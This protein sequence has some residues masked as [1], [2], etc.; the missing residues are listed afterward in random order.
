MN[1]T[2]KS[3]CWT[4]SF[5]GWGLCSI[6]WKAL[7]APYAQDG[8][9][10]VLVSATVLLTVVFLWTR[11]KLERCGRMLLNIVAACGVAGTLLV[12]GQTLGLGAFPFP[13]VV[14]ASCTSLCV[15]LFLALAWSTVFSRVPMAAGGLMLGASY[16][17]AFLVFEGL[18]L[19]PAQAQ[20]GASLVLIPLN[21]ACALLCW[22]RL[23]AAEMS[24]GGLVKPCTLSI[25]SSDIK[26]LI[27]TYPW[28]L[29]LVLA[30]FAF[31]VGI[32]RVHSTVRID[33]ISAGVA[34]VLLVLCTFVSLIRVN[35]FQL[36]KALIPVMLACL[37]IGILS[38]ASTLA[39]QIAI[40]VSYA[41]AQMLLILLLCDK[42]YRFRVPIVLLYGIGRACLSVAA[43]AGTLSGQLCALWLGDGSFWG[44]ELIYGVVLLGSFAA[45]ASWITG[46]DYRTAFAVPQTAQPENDDAE[47]ESVLLR[48]TN[49]TAPIDVRTRLLQS[50]IEERCE[51]LAVEYR[52]SKREAEILVLLGWGKSAKRIEEILV[53]SA[54]TVKTH[55]RH[56]YSKLGIHS[57][58]E[59]DALI[60]VGSVDGERI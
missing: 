33:V 9:L 35:A 30:F 20:S 52:L 41:F 43:V 23:D 13:I 49:D 7:L 54:N 40:N 32:N 51:T 34:G 25:G 19:L 39:A 59:L 47:I 37:L 56:I 5:W 14:V 18:S 44:T 60:D 15:T 1:S 27:K 58:A 11:L 17:V 16:F 38:G 45:I 28:R 31:A 46:S 6:A 53:L 12:V 48:Q 22:Y 36:Y 4:P 26:E 42:A 50:L 57:R 10:S 21:V 8:P 29:V 3:L 55:V 2:L 24:S